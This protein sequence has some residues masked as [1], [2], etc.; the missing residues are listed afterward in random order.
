LLAAGNFISAQKIIK[1][2]TLS[3]H[4]PAAVKFE[5]LKPVMSG[6]AIPQKT[7]NDYTVYGNNSIMLRT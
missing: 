7:K 4:F 1:K 3:R 2:I 6:K 5:W